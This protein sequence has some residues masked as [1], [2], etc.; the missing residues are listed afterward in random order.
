L[1]PA[2]SE[3]LRQYQVQGD[4]TEG[5]KPIEIGFAFPPHEI[6][7][8]NESNQKAGNFKHRRYRSRRYRSKKYR[9]R[10]YHSKKSRSK[11]SRS[12]KYRSR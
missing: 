2:D 10:K 1:S 8:S 9:S 6:T 3:W 12:K 4:K 5:N 11:K 7:V